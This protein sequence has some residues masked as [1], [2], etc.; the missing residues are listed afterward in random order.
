MLG[1]LIHPV[2]LAAVLS[3]A[4]TGCGI[5]GSLEAPPEA[6]ASGTA[7]SPEAHDAGEDSAAPRKEHRPFILDGLIR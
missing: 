7:V 1:K 4:L 6:K 2:I 5:R 3:I